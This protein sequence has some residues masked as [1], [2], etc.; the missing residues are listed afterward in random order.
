MANSGTDFKTT[1]GGPSMGNDGK[2]I[3][4]KKDPGAGSPPPKRE[5]YPKPANGIPVP[6]GGRT[7]LG[8]PVYAQ[9]G[10]GANAMPTTAPSGASGGG[11]PYRNLKG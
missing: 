8:P 6:A 2:G 9:P 5:D 3:D 10:L 4:F 7:P 1:P 11:V